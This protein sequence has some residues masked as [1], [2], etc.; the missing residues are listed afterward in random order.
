M[1]ALRYAALLMLVIWIGGLLVLGAIAAPS[2][3]DVLASRQTPDGRLLAGAVF[4]EMLRRFHLVSYAAGTLLLGTLVLRRILGPRPRRF[5]WRAGIAT[6]MLAAAAFSG[7]VVSARIARVQQQIG[8][9][10]SSLP[11]TDPRRVEFGRL[12]GLSTAVQLI[13]LLGGLMLIY[14][15]IKE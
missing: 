12:H 8:A 14:W 4:G 1:L 6:L 10:P 7:L 3:F 11:V 15:E 9:A 13:P 5:A 2:T